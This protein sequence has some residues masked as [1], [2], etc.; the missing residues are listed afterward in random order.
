MER[1]I[2]C[3]AYNAITAV[4]ELNAAGYKTY[5]EY[6]KGLDEAADTIKWSIV[7]SKSVYDAS[8]KT[9]FVSNTGNDEN[10][11]LSPKT[12]W[13]TLD[14]INDKNSVCEGCNIPHTV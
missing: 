10:D 9:F 8:K 6:A 3:A 13:K 12:A 11:G 14:K 2:P 7:N 5:E 4:D 1:K